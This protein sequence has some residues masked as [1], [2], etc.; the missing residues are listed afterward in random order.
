MSGVTVGDIKRSVASHYR[1]EPSDLSGPERHVEVV[2]KRAVAYKLCV[3]MT[4]ASRSEIG[5]KFGDRDHATVMNGLSYFDNRATREMRAAYHQ[6]REQLLQSAP[7]SRELVWAFPFKSRRTRPAPAPQFIR[8]G[9][10]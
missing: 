1:I 8:R 10:S 6:I 2:Q 3:E 5:R 4:A 7:H 9:S